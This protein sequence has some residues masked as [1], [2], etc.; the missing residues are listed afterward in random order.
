MAP[1]G[2]DPIDEPEES[3]FESAPI[4]ALEDGDTR[5]ATGMVPITGNL[6][7]TVGADTLV[8]SGTVAPPDPLILHQ[9]TLRRI[10][11]L[12]SVIAEMPRRPVGI[13]HNG[14]P[15]WID[16]TFEE[17]DYQAVAAAI[18]VLKSAP[19]PSPEVASAASTLRTVGE[20]IWDYLIRR[21]AYIA[22]QRD[23]FVSEATKSAGAEFG[24]RLVQSPFWFALV[25]SLLAVAAAA[26]DWLA[27][28][29]SA[30]N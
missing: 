10:A 25:S 11:A 4:A 5:A 7:V 28:A 22:K 21:G 29:H 15:E 20:R 8:A 23:T 3:F 1:Q 19:T 6:A 26:F 12:E 18:S 27:A 16:H 13:G 14:P 9:E 24:K 30:L 2:A 17:G